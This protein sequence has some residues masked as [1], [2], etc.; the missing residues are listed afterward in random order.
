MIRFGGGMRIL[1]RFVPEPVRAAAFVVSS[2][3]EAVFR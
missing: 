2:R 1:I 3:G